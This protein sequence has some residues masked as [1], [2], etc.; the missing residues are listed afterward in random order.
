MIIISVL[1]FDTKK[2]EITKIETKKVKIWAKHNVDIYQ[3]LKIQ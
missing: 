2:K 3:S 1:S